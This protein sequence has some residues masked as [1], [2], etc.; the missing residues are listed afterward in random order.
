MCKINS[1]QEFQLLTSRYWL[2]IS[3]QI[4]DRIIY[5]N[6]I[7]KIEEFDNLNWNIILKDSYFD[8]WTK[9]NVIDYEKIQCL[10]DKFTIAYRI[11]EDMDPEIFN[12]VMLNPT[13]RQKLK[14]Y[15]TFN[16]HN[17]FLLKT[18]YNTYRSIKYHV[19]SFSAES[20]SVPSNISWFHYLSG[21]HTIVSMAYKLID[22]HDGTTSMWKLMNHIS[23][24][25]C[26]SNEQNIKFLSDEDKLKSIRNEIKILRHNFVSHQNYD[27]MDLSWFYSSTSIGGPT[28]PLDRIWEII[29]DIQNIWDNWYNIFYN[30]VYQPA[31]S[32]FATPQNFKEFVYKFEISVYQDGKEIDLDED[33]K[34]S[35]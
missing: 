31:F 27:H 35:S 5:S 15:F 12:G 4:N 32:T 22:N 25:H 33:I 2:R 26:L 21:L 30:T 28:I 13:K 19:A 9:K 18:Y 3:F 17:L 11:N 1:V 29:N 24:L 14:K 23:G 20:K 34:T 10:K 16:S 7:E 6:E 8:I